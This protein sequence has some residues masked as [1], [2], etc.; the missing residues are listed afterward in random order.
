MTT[1]Q[2]S[3]R[4]EAY[5]LINAGYG[6]DYLAVPASIAGEFMHKMRRVVKTRPL[7]AD[8]SVDYSAPEIYKMYSSI[9]GKFSTEIMSAEEADAAFVAGKL[10]DEPV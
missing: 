8:G 3:N 4:H 5:L 2:P 1:K 6:D 9:R 10:S 7:K